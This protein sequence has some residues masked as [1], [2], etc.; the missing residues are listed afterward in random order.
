[1]FAFAIVDPRS[2]S[3]FLARDR[4]GIKPLYYHATPGRFLFA[5][6]LKALFQDE[7]VPRVADMGVLYRFLLHRV[8]DA[9]DET[10]FAGVKRL[11]PGHF[12]TVTADGR[13]AVEEVLGRR[14]STPSSRRR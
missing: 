4:L 5:S 9:G 10:F 14:R 8:H 3:I 1:M 7:G 13:T 11:L 12:M 2:H 6:E